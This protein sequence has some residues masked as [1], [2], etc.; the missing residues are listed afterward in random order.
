MVSVQNLLFRGIFCTGEKN[1]PPGYVTNFS[2]IHFL[3]RTQAWKIQILDFLKTSAHMHF[4]RFYFYAFCCNHRDHIKLE[5]V[6]EPKIGIK[7]NGA[8]LIKFGGGQN[9]LLRTFSVCSR[10][11]RSNNWC[12]GNCLVF[13]FASCIEGK[14]ASLVISRPLLL[15]P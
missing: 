7:L 6:R 8:I 12:L 13:V 4:R 11:S 9:V 10:T 1:I 2:I 14:T 15:L 5:G 3:N